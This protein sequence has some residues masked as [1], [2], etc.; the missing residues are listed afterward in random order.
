MRGRV[1]QLPVRTSKYLPGWYCNA[2]NSYFFRSVFCITNYDSRRTA[3]SQQTTFSSTKAKK[4]I[5]TLIS[6]WT[7]GWKTK[8]TVFPPHQEMYTTKNA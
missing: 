8:K 5:S 3:T 6:H 1:Q 2:R 4:W 7:M